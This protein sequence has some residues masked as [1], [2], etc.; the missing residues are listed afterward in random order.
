M[1]DNAAGDT[2]NDDIVLISVK[3]QYKTWCNGSYD[4]A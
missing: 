3:A 1:S 2:F 4:Y